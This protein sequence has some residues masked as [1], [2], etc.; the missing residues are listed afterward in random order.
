LKKWQEKRL[1]ISE[2]KIQKSPKESLRLPTGQAKCKMQNGI[3]NQAPRN[4]Q[5]QNGNG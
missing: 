3:N 4:K 1:D 5:I 2:I